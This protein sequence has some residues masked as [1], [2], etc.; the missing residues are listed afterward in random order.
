MVCDCVG[1]YWVVFGGFER[2]AI[3]LGRIGL[4]LV[5][6]GGDVVLWYIGRSQCSHYELLMKA[7]SH[8]FLISFSF[9]A[10]PLKCR[11]L[12]SLF[13]DLKQTHKSAQNLCCWQPLQFIFENDGS[14]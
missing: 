14:R 11:S 9:Y 1:L 8:L 2:C 13:G 6:L 10:S 5:V 7:M 12:V 3:V 4:R